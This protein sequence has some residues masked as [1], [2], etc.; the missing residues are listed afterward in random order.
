MPVAAMIMVGLFSAAMV[1]NVRL[2]D[3]T[4][5]LEQQNST[6]AA[7]VG[8]SITENQLEKKLMEDKLNQ[9]QLTNY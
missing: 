1:L 5:G 6:L 7:Q 8:L 2:S 4:Q 3:R 9:L